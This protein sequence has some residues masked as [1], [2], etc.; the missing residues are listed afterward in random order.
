MLSSNGETTFTN[1]Y[2]RNW[3]VDVLKQWTYIWYR[4]SYRQVSRWERSVLILYSDTL[5]K[6]YICYPVMGNLMVIVYIHV[7]YC[8]P[9]YLSGFVTEVK[10]KPRYGEFMCVRRNWLLWY[11]VKETIISTLLR[12]IRSVFIGEQLWIIRNLESQEEIGFYLHIIIIIE[13]LNNRD[14]NF[15]TPPREEGL[16]RNL[17]DSKVSLER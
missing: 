9:L 8:L 7:S 16:L 3:D 4:L 11:S 1:F 13:L 6:G 2:L 10:Y 15:H 12:Q 5:L 14:R 17:W